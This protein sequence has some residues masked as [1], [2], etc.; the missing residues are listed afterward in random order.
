MRPR[1]NILQVSLLTGIGDCIASLL[2]RMTVICTAFSLLAPHQAMEAMATGTPV[3]A[4]RQ[5]CSALTVQDG[6]HI[7]VA[8]NPATFAQ[9]VLRLLDDVTLRREI[10]INGRNYVEERH[11]WRAIAGNLENIYA[12]VMERWRS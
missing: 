2:A 1:E 3:V 11:D 5:A 10:A 7:L 9:Q 6:T 8:D 4:S 12:E